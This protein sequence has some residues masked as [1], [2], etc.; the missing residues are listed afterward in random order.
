VSEVL[1][2]QLPFSF[3]LLLALHSFHKRPSTQNCVRRD[4]KNEDEEGRKGK[5]KEE[6]Q[7]N[8]R[9]QWKQDEEGEIS[10]EE[11]QL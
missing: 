5:V 8:K 7:K 11:E 1:K 6:E 10:D 4:T 9:R 2:S 3:A